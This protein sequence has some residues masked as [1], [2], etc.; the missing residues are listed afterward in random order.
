MTN[1]PPQELR[2]HDISV[3]SLDVTRKAAFGAA[4][5]NAME[6]FDFGIYSYLA[7][8][9][10]KIF[11]P[12]VD[13]DSQLVASFATFAAAFIARPAG[14]VF[15]GRLGDRIGRKTVLLATLSIMAL[16]TFCIGLIPGYG[17]IGISS[18]IFLLLARLLQGFSSGG[19]YAGAMTY[20]VEYSPD[21]R[22]GMMASLLEIGTLVG[23]VLGA[24]LVTALTAW[25]GADKM[26]L[27]GWRIPFFVAAPLSI[28]AATFRSRLG[29]T[30]VFESSNKNG[31]PEESSGTFVEMFRIHWRPMLIGLG[32]VFFYNV[33]NYM[34]LSYMP[35]YLSS[36][37]G[38]GETKGLLLILMVMVIMIPIVF[39]IGFM[40]DRLGRNPII[41][42]G[43]AGLIIL[44]VPAFLLIKNGTDWIVFSGL[45]LL[46]AHLAAF[47]GTMTSTLPA[48]FFT[49]VRYGALAIT[50]N[51]STSVFGGTT[52]LVLALLVKSTHN[53]MMPAY[54]LIVTACIGLFVS[55][56]VRETASKSLRGSSPVVEHPEEIQE[57][58]AR[59]EEATWWQE[60]PESQISQKSE[61]EEDG[62]ELS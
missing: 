50:Y 36:V 16:S 11:F 40:S 42:G 24:G 7:V 20:V 53:D 47:E 34:V 51:L 15:F 37:L 30:P 54:F 56:F 61:K 2:S 19:E 32:L 55:F 14:A 4:L 18:S 10:G 45:V 62:S 26:L 39:G 28:L 13:P 52:P 38:Y 46:G 27:W 58:L 3:V 57:V 9:I 29:E 6:W 17:S 23:F 12:H 60:E 8:T 48:L 59:Q 41:R 35:A 5:G 33:I 1:D 44:S 21:K 22:R 43:L 25:I 49:E 31:D